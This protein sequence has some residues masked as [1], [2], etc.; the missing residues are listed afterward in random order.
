[1]SA[2][3]VPDRARP[4]AAEL[5]ARIAAGELGARDA[6]EAALLRGERLAGELGCYLETLA[7]SARERAARIDRELAEGA[8]PGPLTGVPFALKANLCLAGAHASC[9][10]RALAGWRAPYTATGVERLLEAGAIPVAVTNMDEFGMGSSGENSAVGPARNPWDPGRAPGGSSSGSAVA[11]AAGL[12]PFALGSD[13][14]GSVRQPAALCG[15]T[16]FKPSW[17]RISRYGLVAFASSL[18]QIGV[19]APSALG[20]DPVYRALAGPDPRDATTIQTPA[21]AAAPAWAHDP[22]SLSGLRLGVLEGFGERGG[23]DPT[24]RAS[25]L[26]SGLDAGAREALERAVDRLVALGAERAPVRLPHGHLALA[27]YYVIAMAE[28]SSNLARYDGVRYGARF[29]PEATCGDGPDRLEAMLSATRAAGFGP[30]VERRVLLGTH[31]LRSGFADAWYQRAARVRRLVADDY[32][33]AFEAVDVIVSPTATGPAFALGERSGDPLA[34][35]SSDRFTVPPS[36]AGLPAASLPAGLS[37]D[38]PVGLQVVAPHG[39]DERVL[40]LARAF[41]NATEHHRALPPLR[42][43]DPGEQTAR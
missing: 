19:L 21:V 29:E 13:T 28:A 7:A 43:A 10:S 8:S 14:G 3:S 42:A 18:D 1:M 15:V 36:L 26:D 34:M 24:G 20:L 16:G 23:S 32:A 33:R 4:T 22:G 30:E 35:Y 37:G 27:A 39:E 40:A 6:V 2:E 31:V 5:S 38:L 41:Q 17:G 9:A 25:G 12:V 11:V